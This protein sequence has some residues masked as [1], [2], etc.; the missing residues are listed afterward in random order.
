MNSFTMRSSR[1]RN[2]FWYSLWIVF[3][4]PILSQ[5]MGEMGIKSFL[6]NA[7][8]AAAPKKKAEKDIPVVAHIRLSGDLDEAPPEDSP[9]GTVSENLAA[10]LARIKKAKEDKNVKALVLEIGGLE[11]GLFGFGKV[12][13]VRQAIFDF[14]KSGKKAIAY[15][16]DAEGLDY[17]IACACDQ[18]VL[19]EGGTF[20]VMGL[21]LEMSFYKDAMDRIG[22]KADFLRMGDAKGY[23]E[24]YYRTS[25]SP[26]NRKQY[27]LVLDDLYENEMLATI[28]VSRPI[29]KANISKMKAIIDGSPYTAKKAKEIGLI[30]QIAYLA[31]T[32]KSL[33]TESK[34]EKVIRDYGKAKN[35]EDE[36]F[37]ALLNKL[38]SPPKKSKSKKNKIAVIYA[39]GAIEMGKGGGGLM[40]GSSVGSETMVKAIREAEEDPTVKAIVLRVDSPGGSALASDLI[41]NELKR[42]KK[43]TIASMGNIA[44]SGGYYISMGCSKVYAEPGS[45]TGSIGVVY[46]KIV[47]G[48]TYNWIGIKTENLNRGANAG[49]SSS[50]TMFST[51]EKKAVTEVMQDVYDQFL[52][53]TVANRQ[54]AGKAITK[55]KLLPL[56]GGRIWTGR[57]LLERGLVDSNGTLQDAI[58][59]AKKQAKLE[60]EPELLILPK[61]PSILDRFLEG[62]S[63]LHSNL[64]S[65]KHFL[66]AEI[67]EEFP[68]LKSHLQQ[69]DLM[70]RMQKE[71]AWLMMP[72]QIRLK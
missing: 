14:R 34:A 41:W 6:G 58:L 23:G 38:M 37:L 70:M 22:L 47:F 20:A 39:V 25:M 13:E 59:E 53:K 10:K 71:R 63:G 43:P 65:K 3:L 24:P 30:D 5:A 40:G 64:S 72:Y 52:D 49:V 68:G 21:Q 31:D 50:R 48:D 46:G 27:N 67:A 61:L 18:I 19:P 26:E 32:E 2:R 17:L 44:A 11:M 1:N 54:A 8:H 16:Y 62:K 42:S 28:A 12:N 15:L 69:I 29:M 45:L 35:D 57:Q 55:D 36:N 66:I 60:E 33:Q 9:F 7:V 51:G 4:I 56:A